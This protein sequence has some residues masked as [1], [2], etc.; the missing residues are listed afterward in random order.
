[1]EKTCFKCG[2]KVSLVRGYTK[3]TDGYICNNCLNRYGIGQVID[4]KSRS[5]NEIKNAIESRPDKIF[6]FAENN[7]VK[8]NIETLLADD[9]KHKLIKIKNSIIEY[10]NIL[11]YSLI[12][13]G[14]AVTSGSV[15]SAVAGGLL[16]GETGAIVGGI[17][18]K[19][20]TSD[21]VTSVKIC[22]NVKNFPTNCLF[23]EIL[24]SSSPL[25]KTSIFYKNIQ[26]LAY[27]CLSILE[28]VVKENTESLI[29]QN[30]IKNYNPNISIADEIK[31]MKELVDEGL[32]TQNEFE[33]QKNRLLNKEIQTETKAEDK[34]KNLRISIDDQLAY[35]YYVNSEDYTYDDQEIEENNYQEIDNNQSEETEEYYKEYNSKTEQTKRKNTKK[36]STPFQKIGIVFIE[37]IRYLIGIFFILMGIT[38]LSVGNYNALAI[39]LIFLGASF[40]PIIYKKLK[41]KAFMHFLVPVIV[42]IIVII[43]LLIMS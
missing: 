43:V 39:G 1:M 12:E 18:G 13:D 21:A 31:K 22:V 38:G 14:A 20:K 35:H 11:S 24:N 29:N 19:R 27:Q 30:N 25:K 3:L 41:L 16:F 36:P 5:I 34:N 9:T 2:D 33:T 37:I 42:F 28:R 7:A 17:T 26:N 6:Y 8:T 10:E 15:G 4:R 40:F 23:I 32:L